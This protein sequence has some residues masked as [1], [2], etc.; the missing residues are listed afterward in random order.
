[1]HNVLAQNPSDSIVNRRTY[2]KKNWA[3]EPTSF[4]LSDDE[5]KKIVDSDQRFIKKVSCDFFSS[6]LKLLDFS[7]CQ[8]VCNNKYTGKS[9]WTMMFKCKSQNCS[10]EFKFKARTEK[11][12]KLYSNGTANC[13]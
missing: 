5:W 4:Q 6:K 12:F 11:L 1:M 2:N 10:K 8:F 3:L 9:N 13:L 7:N